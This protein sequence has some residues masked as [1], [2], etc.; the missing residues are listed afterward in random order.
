M[1]VKTNV[2]LVVDNRVS[3]CKYCKK[4]VYRDKN[5]FIDPFRPYQYY[6][7]DCFIA[8]LKDHPLSFVKL[9]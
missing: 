6:H 7:K 9:S 5:L 1:N 8:I 2:T 3:D 4:G